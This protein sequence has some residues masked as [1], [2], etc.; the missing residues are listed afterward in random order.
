VSRWSRGRL[1]ARWLGDG[2]LIEAEGRI[3][4]DPGLQSALAVRD[5]PVA[6][7]LLTGCTTSSIAGLVAVLSVTDGPIEVWTPLWD[8]RAS[9]FIEGWTRSF[10][11]DIVLETLSER[12]P[13]HGGTASLRAVEI[14]GVTRGLLRFDHPDGRILVSPIATAMTADLAVHRVQAWDRPSTVDVWAIREDGAW[15]SGPAA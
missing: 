12:A 3:L 8:D 13:L 15:L 10:P 7:I 5:I 2:L 9:M 14:D 6:A 1:S 4:V 11:R